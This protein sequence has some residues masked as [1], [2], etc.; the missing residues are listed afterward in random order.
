M[1]PSSWDGNRDGAV[2]GIEVGVRGM[3]GISS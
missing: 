1:V 3:G 2:M